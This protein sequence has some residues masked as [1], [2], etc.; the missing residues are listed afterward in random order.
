MREAAERIAAELRRTPPAGID[1][2][3]IGEGVELLHWL[4]D[5]HFTFL[6]YR[7]YSLTGTDTDEEDALVGLNG[8]GLGILRHDQ[9]RESSSYGRLTPQARSKSRERSLLVLT[10]ANSRA[11]VHRTGYLDYIGVKTFDETGRVVGERRFLGLFA[12]SAYTGSVLYIPVVRRKVSAVL[13]R[14]ETGDGARTAR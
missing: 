8:T 11:T 7:E 2:E 5:G 12:S 10:K 9:R 1:A 3:E 13:D 14:G 4:A 6:G